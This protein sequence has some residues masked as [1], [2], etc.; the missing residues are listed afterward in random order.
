[1]RVA[2]VGVEESTSMVVVVVDAPNHDTVSGDG[3]QGAMS[4][5]VMQALHVVVFSVQVQVLHV[6]QVAQW[7]VVPVLA[8]RFRF[9]VFVHGSVIG[10]LCVPAGP[11]NGILDHGLD[12][13]HIA[14]FFGGGVWR[15]LP[16]VMVTVTVTGRVPSSG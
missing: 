9:I 11:T 5:V 15:R 10:P 16:V 6:A 2:R 4:G 8:F 3:G 14:G 13:T 1:V 12:L 7:T